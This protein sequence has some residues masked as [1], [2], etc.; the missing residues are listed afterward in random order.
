MP[1]LC[2]AAG[3][4][5][6]PARLQSGRAQNPVAQ[7]AGRA[8]ACV[9]APGTE[10][11]EPRYAG[12]QKPTSDPFWSA[13]SKMACSPATATSGLRAGLCRTAR[14]CRR[15]KAVLYRSA[16]ARLRLRVQ[17]AGGIGEAARELAGQAGSTLWDIQLE[18][19]A[20]TEQLLVQYQASAQQ[21]T[22]QPKRAHTCCTPASAR[23]AS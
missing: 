13:H 17:H 23:T 3:A 14:V 2:A 11:A 6:L 16:E 20:S 10:S 1:A 7:R 12:V 18:I 5:A 15:P 21:L 19:Q 8:K 4:T 9:H 22:A